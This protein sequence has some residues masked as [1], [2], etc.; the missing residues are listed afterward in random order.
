MKAA[1]SVSVT[2]IGLEPDGSP[3]EPGPSLVTATVSWAFCSPCAKAP[4]CDASTDTV[5]RFSVRFTH[6][7]LAAPKVALALPELKKRLQVPLALEPSVKMSANVEEP[8][9]G[10]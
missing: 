5:G 9:E 3:V 4:L 7:P 2:V 8:W 6:Q 10:A 1:P